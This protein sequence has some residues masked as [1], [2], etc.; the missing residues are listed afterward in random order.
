MIFGSEPG[1]KEG[2]VLPVEI[3]PPA[4]IRL[5]W[6][7]LLKQLIQDGENDGPI[8]NYSE[9]QKLNQRCGKDRE[10]LG[11]LVR[12]NPHQRPEVDY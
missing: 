9:I 1:N 11:I 3:I 2:S 12:R 6:C 8:L 10:C 5:I 4:G 7:F